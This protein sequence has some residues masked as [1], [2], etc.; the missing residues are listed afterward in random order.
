MQSSCMNPM[1]AKLSSSSF[2]MQSSCMD[3]I[4]TTRAE[5]HVMETTLDPNNHLEVRIKASQINGKYKSIIRT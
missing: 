4:Q 5:T 2:P 1:Q 3:S